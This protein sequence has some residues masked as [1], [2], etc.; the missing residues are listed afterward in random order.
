MY[1]YTMYTDTCIPRCTVW[2]HTYAYIY[3]HTHTHTHTQI[4][5]N[6][7]IQIDIEHEW[8]C[9]T[10][11][12]WPGESWVCD[13]S[14]RYPETTKDTRCARAVICVSVYW[15]GTSS[16]GATNNETKDTLVVLQS[17]VALFLFL[18]FFLPLCRSALKCK[19]PN[20]NLLGFHV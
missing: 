6:V 4:H 11:S 10:H 5:G 15:R 17:S 2:T 1:I 20:G 16:R 9:E 19:A 14:K 18:S 3:I 8:M 7:D 12:S 13:F